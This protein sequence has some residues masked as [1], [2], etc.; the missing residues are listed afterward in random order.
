MTTRFG[1][2]HAAVLAIVLAGGPGQRP[3]TAQTNYRVLGW[4]KNHIALVNAGGAVEWE[5][6]NE[7]GSMHDIQALTN[8]NLIYHNGTTVR[9]VDREKKTVWE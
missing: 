2:A 4:D 9:E 6:P 7:A 8:G 5:Y 1:M 3:A